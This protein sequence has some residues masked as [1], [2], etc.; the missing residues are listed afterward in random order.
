MTERM[1]ALRDQFAAELAAAEVVHGAGAFDAG[2]DAFAD[3]AGDG[4]GDAELG[5]GLADG[6]AADEAAGGDGGIARGPGVAGAGGVAEVEAGEAADE[7][8]G[9]AACAGVAE[10]DEGGGFAIVLAIDDD[11]A[12][13][14][15][16]AAI[17]EAA[18]FGDGPE[19]E[20]SP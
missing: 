6:H 7:L 19:D 11:G 8:E 5:G 15:F 4:G 18:V 3:T 16:I 1:A 17:E 14:N 13:E 9:A 10:A 12:E 20:V 2:D